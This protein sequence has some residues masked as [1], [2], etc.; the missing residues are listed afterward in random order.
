MVGKYVR[1]KEKIEVGIKKLW[2]EYF[3]HILILI[4]NKRIKWYNIKKVSKK[5]IC[6]G[7]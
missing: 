4:A 1:S 3:R 5:E 7:Y 2:R 6:D